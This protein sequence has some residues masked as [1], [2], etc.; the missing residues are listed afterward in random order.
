MLPERPGRA[1]RRSQTEVEERGARAT[2]AVVRVGPGDE[3][4]VRAQNAP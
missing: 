3:R 2:Q 1:G 4:C